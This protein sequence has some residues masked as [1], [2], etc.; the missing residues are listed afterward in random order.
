MTFAIAVVCFALSCR[1]V[2][3]IATRLGEEERAL[4]VAVAVGVNVYA[5]IALSLEIWDFFW[6][7]QTLGLERW[8]AQQLGLSV[9]WT[10]YAGG[11]IAV[12]LAR[13]S[14]ML[15]WQALALFALV[16]AKVF[17]YDMSSLDKIY[18]IAS[19]LVLGVL[20]LGVSFV[21]QRRLTAQKA[22]KKS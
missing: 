18:R 14:A 10:L 20:L 7:T 8:L 4:F 11:L 3:D 17:L 21:Y 15:R 9:L 5:L 1:F 16:V 6:R 19:F 13:R 22:E 12:G 2:R